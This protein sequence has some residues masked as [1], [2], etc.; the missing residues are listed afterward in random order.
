MGSKRKE[1][2][3]KNKLTSTQEFLY[4]RDFKKA[5]RAGGYASSGKLY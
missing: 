5:D 2:L 3:V 4:S 1:K